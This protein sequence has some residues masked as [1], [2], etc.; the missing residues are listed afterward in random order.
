MAIFNFTPASILADAQ[1]G[2]DLLAN[3]TK[4]DIVGVFDQQSFSQVFPGARPMK[5][6]VRETSR[7]MDYP[8]ETGVTLSDHH[9]INPTEIELM[10]VINSLEYGSAYQAI[11]N[12]WVNATLLMVQTRTGVYRNMIVAQMPHEETPDMYDAIYQTVRLR[13]VIFV[14]PSSIAAPTQPAN[15]SPVNPVNQNTV[16]RGFQSPVALAGSALS[17]ANVINL[18]GL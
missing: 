6:S 8:V 17:L 1:L 15:Y 4:V 10:M 13:E 11:R 18:W 16:T 3:I 5:A 12:A 9:V 7:V 2:L 14:A